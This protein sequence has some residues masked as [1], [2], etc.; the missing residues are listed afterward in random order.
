MTTERKNCDKSPFPMYNKVRKTK[1]AGSVKII[2]EQAD[3]QETEIHI[4]GNIAG[5]EVMA[6]LQSL[7][8]KSS[9]KL[10]LYKEDEQFVIDANEIIFIEVSGTKTLAF[11]KEDCF[12]IRSKLYELKE[13]LEGFAFAQINKSTL[14]NINRIH[15]IQAEFSGNYSVKLKERKE[16]LTISRKYFK[17]FKERV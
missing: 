8:K 5:P 1:E 14:I 10:L 6:I 17:E 4:R 7:E 3:L 2:L 11:T 15:S 9:S 16:I 13:Q 12:E